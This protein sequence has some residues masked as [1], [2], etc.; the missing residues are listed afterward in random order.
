MKNRENVKQID[1][2]LRR[3]VAH[4]RPTSE[5]ASEFGRDLERL[6]V[7]ANEARSSVAMESA[8]H[9]LVAAGVLPWIHWLITHNLFIKNQPI[10][11]Q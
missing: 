11:S 3:I 6:R 8:V 1:V 4:A 9:A 5:V 7:R 10:N 2:F